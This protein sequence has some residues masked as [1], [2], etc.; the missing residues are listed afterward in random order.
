MKKI[1]TLLAVLLAAMI[2]AGCGSQTLATACEDHGGVRQGS[3]EVDAH[4]HDRDG[5]ADDGSGGEARCQ[6]GAEAEREE[7]A[8]PNTGYWSAED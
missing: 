7:G 6:D 4:D 3:V 8:D 5:E 2:A 1:Y